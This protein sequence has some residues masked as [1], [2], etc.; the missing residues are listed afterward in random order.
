MA[1]KAEIAHF[2]IWQILRSHKV[3]RAMLEFGRKAG[4]EKF[5]VLMDL[6]WTLSD[7]DF[8]VKAISP[9]CESRWRLFHLDQDTFP[10]TDLAVLVEPD[11]IMVA[12]SPRHLLMAERNVKDYSCWQRTRI[13]PGLLAEFRRR[14]ID[15]TFR[16]IIF[17]D[18]RVLE[19][20]RADPHFQRRVELLKSINHHDLAFATAAWGSL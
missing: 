15:N 2:I 14:T 9:L 16:E 5:E 7:G 1:I 4:K 13:D 3:I 12:L 18:R 10:L 8:M 17:S 19:E 20:W 11:T 6:K